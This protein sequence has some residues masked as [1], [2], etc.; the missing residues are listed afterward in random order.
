[1]DAV[2]VDPHQCAVTAS[3]PLLWPVPGPDRH[4]NP[5][6]APGYDPHVPCAAHDP[7]GSGRCAALR[8]HGPSYL[9]ASLGCF[10]AHL[11]MQS[12]TLDRSATAVLYIILH[13]MCRRCSE[14]GAASCYCQRATARQRPA[15]VQ[16]GLDESTCRRNHWPCT[17]AAHRPPRTYIKYA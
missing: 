12:R 5:M 3:R 10:H 17:H 7:P 2:S 1:M 11:W 14:H 8:M 13:C 9:H 16:A 15:H 6:R 4:L